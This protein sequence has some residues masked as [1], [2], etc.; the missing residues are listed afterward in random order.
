[1]RGGASHGGD[2]S[3]LDRGEHRA[4]SGGSFET[5]KAAN[6]EDGIWGRRGPGMGVKSFALIPYICYSTVK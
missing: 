2:R 6:S 4:S 5:G 1:M 3:Y